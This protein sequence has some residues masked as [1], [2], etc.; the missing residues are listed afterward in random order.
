MDFDA[1]FATMPNSMPGYYDIEDRSYAKDDDAPSHSANANVFGNFSISPTPPTRTVPVD[2][3]VKVNGMYRLLD[4]VG[5]S[6]SNGHVDK[7][8]IAQDSLQRFINAI[9]PG[10]Y[11]SI[12]KVD[13][14]T[15]DRFMI[16]PLGV[17]GSKPEIVKLLQTIGAVDDDTAGLLLASTDNIDSGSNLTTGLYI[18]RADLNR[19]ATG[20]AGERY[21]VIYWPE[22]ATW[23]DSAASSVCRNRVTFM[24][25]LT[26]ICDQII[27][28]L[29][30]EHSK[31]IVWNDEESDA[32]SVDMSTCEFDRVYSFEV[33]ETNEQEENAVSYPG[34][35]MDSHH[36]MHHEVP[37]GYQRDPAA[38][39]PRLLRGETTQGFFTVS[40]IPPQPCPEDYNKHTKNNA[41]V[42]SEE[43]EEDAVEILVRIAVEGIFPESCA[44]WCTAKKEICAR[45]KQELAKKDDAVCQDVAGGE[46]SLRRVLHEAVTKDVMKLFPSIERGRLSR[47]SDDLRTDPEAS[48]CRRIS[49]LESLYHNFQSTYQTHMQKAG[50][51]NVLQRNSYFATW[52]LR[53]ISIRSLLEKHRL[54]QPE[55]HKKLPNVGM[56]ETGSRFH[57]PIASEDTLK[58][59]MKKLAASVSDSQFIHDMKTIGDEEMR[60]VIEQVENL[61]YEQLGYSIDKAVGAM[62]RV[63][64]DMQKKRCRKLMQ[65]KVEIEGKKLLKAALTEFIRDIN[66]LSVGRRDSVVY[67]E[68]VDVSRSKLHAW[69]HGQEYLFTGHRE[70]TQ[71][72]RLRL[73]VHLM[74][75]TSDDKHN[76]QLDPKYIPRPI[77]NDRLS[78]SFCIPIDMDIA[79]HQILESDKL[80]LVL[81]DRD[82]VSIYLDRI[83]EMDNAIQRE[84]PNKCL[85]REKLGEGAL[86]AFDETKRALVVCAPTKLQLYFFI[87]D[88]SYKTLQAQGTPIN[89]TT[90][91]SSTETTI[92][93]VAFAQA[94][95]FS[96]VT[97]QFRPASLQLPSIPDSIFSSPD[98]S[99]LLVH[100]AQTQRHSSLWVRLD[101]PE[102]PIH[103]AVLTSVVDRG[104]I[105]LM[106]LD[107]VSGSVQSI[108][109]KITQ[110]RTELMFRENDNGNASNN[111]MGHTLHNSLLDCHAEVWSRFPVVPA[112]KRRTST[113]TSEPQDKSITFIAESHSLPF[114]SYFSYLIQTFERTT[115]KPTGGELRRI[116]VLAKEYSTF[117]DEVI[118]NSDWEVSRYLVGEWLVELL[119]LIPIQI[120]VCRENRFVPLADGVLSSDLERTLLGAEV[121]KIVD[122]LSFG[123]YESI[124]QSYLAT[125]PVKVVSSMGQQSVGKSFALNH[126][127][128]TSFAGSA[129][130]TTE[131]VWMSVTPTEDTLIVALDFEGVDSI[132][133]SLQE[134]TLL[135][136]FNTAISNLVLF[137]NN[138]AFSRD[139][140]GL[141][142]S[143][144]SSASILD[145][146]ANPSLFQ[147]TLVIIIKDVVD[148]DKKEIV[149]EFRLKFRG[150]VKEEQKANF[151]SRLHRG[152]LDIIPWPVIESSEFY[153]LLSALKKRLDQQPISHP[154]AGE[155]LLTIKTLMA[156]LKANDWGSLSQST[157]EHR[158]RALSAILPI[159]LA[160]GYSE[161]EPDLEPLKNL[162]T[163]LII[164]SDDTATFFALSGRERIPQPDVEMHLAALREAWGRSTPRQSMQD[165]EWTSELA[166][167]IN[168][169]MDLRVAHVRL[170]LDTN[171]QRFQAGHAIIDDLRRR[172]ESMVIE[173]K[174]NARLCRVQ[175]ASCHLLCV[176]NRL[177]EGD[178]SCETTHTCAYNCRFCGGDP[179]TCGIPA[180]HPG[181]HVCVVN[182]HLCGGPCKLSGRRG[183]LGNCTKAV[184]HVED[185]HICSALV[186]MCGEVWGI[187]LPLSYFFHWSWIPLAL[188]SPEMNLP[189]GMTFSCQEACSIPSDEDHE[190]HSCDMRQCPVTCDLC[191][192]FCVLPHF[193]GLEP[194]SAHLCGETHSC[195]ELCSMPGICQID[196]APQSIEA[197]FT[198][199][200]ETFQ[201]TKP[202]HFC[203]T[204]CRNCGYFCT[205]PLG[206]SQ[207]EHETSHGSMTQ[208]RWS[209]EGPD[210]TGIELKGRKFSSDDEG[211]PMMC[212]L[213]CSS[214]GR[215]IHIDYCRSEDGVPCSGDELQHINASLR[216]IP[217]PDKAKDA[218]THRLHW[219]RMGMLD[220]FSWCSLRRN[221]LL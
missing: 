207:K 123:W 24:R 194:G 73:K 33:A 71:A 21:Y 116:K 135:V 6:G 92:L 171:L 108:A 58:R 11:A 199:R 115:R 50:F 140:S 219:R 65:L 44:R 129:M 68:R 54:L 205:L 218:I 39:T 202:F 45:R 102:F 38:L 103:N 7:V 126:L 206:H 155:F 185:E 95:I 190:V 121:S 12:T 20:V 133:R 220:T 192:R 221:L 143:F 208:T 145:P 26:K 152:K 9:S 99:C 198:G 186:H 168:R 170:W 110:K 159:A 128:D 57:G 98:G 81:L 212:N 174:T 178:H 112:V 146:A 22:D 217:D 203:E 157:T 66:A 149:R 72:P 119:C 67:V 197:T 182:I 51:D 209:I 18:V 56:R 163:D 189:G 156:K 137:R 78:P 132:E 201:Y 195:S 104:R 120:A 40:Y 46:V 134:D 144:Q 142:R 166:A 93:H 124:F 165:S 153:K 31:S 17:Y 86:F 48:A 172:F 70:A 30:P 191:K 28:L 183:C 150:I 94:R 41:L 97:L 89:L 160:T 147:S 25:F 148:S 193:H 177:H 16:K 43:L 29:S 214:M 91:Y 32:E 53:L 77:T 64:L 60:T 47:A 49:E 141:F 2:L 100:H 169:L 75:L 204:R 14:K 179:K 83:P 175:C 1:L 84:R 161:V 216:M 8:V 136:L 61:V 154:V 37:L 151:I 188:C 213:V 210:G 10:A 27:A 85:N 125:K 4:V 19:D 138:F 88:E 69:Y 80:L 215:H 131:G 139:I 106:G 82:K 167:H 187:Q 76:M 211:A 107:T 74:D 164:E 111:R 118:M 52:K 90:W 87:F 101:V 96:F 130:R 42:L 13:F 23:D 63:V 158:A 173:M 105:F 162:D 59:E 62:T 35:Q 34:F 184:G 113:S 196:N 109:I 181:E 200:Q 3:A 127:L 55:M 36:V 117:R 79:F 122:K 15:L 180:G 5:E 114:E 176:L